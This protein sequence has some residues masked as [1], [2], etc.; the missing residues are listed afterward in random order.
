MFLMG[1]KFALYGQITNG[2]VE[3]IKN[4]FL[5]AKPRLHCHI[6]ILE[7]VFLISQPS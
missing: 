2:I 5:P 1:M 6:W 3:D 7:D 4:L